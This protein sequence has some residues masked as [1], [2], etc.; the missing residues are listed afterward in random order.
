MITLT[1]Q[2]ATMEVSL[3]G[4]ELRRYT[5]K[6]GRECLWSGDPYAWT[7]VA[8]VLFPTIGALKNQTVLIEN[9]AF[10]IPK[11]GL[12]RHMPFTV[13]EQGPDFITL[14]VTQ[15]EETKACYPFDFAFFVT[16]RFVENGFETILKIENHSDR[17]M[18]F[19]VG[20]HPAFSC[21]MKEGESFEEYVVEFEKPEE[22]R[23]LLMATG[24][25]LSGEEIVPLGENHRTL[26]LDYSAFDK[27]DTYVFSDINSR[28]I[29][30]IHKDTRKG[31]KVSFPTAPVLA[32][33]TMTNKKAPYLC[34]EP[35]EGLPALENETGHFED[36]PYCIKLDM[37]KSY[38]FSYK[39]QEI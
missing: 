11:H 25:I 27:R 26:S 30:L 14:C 28:S 33:W 20:G 4:G 12:V 32:V 37:G 38:S 23:S 9:K 17:T 5:N 35:W 3:K 15:T 18:P 16:H 22:G 13:H 10:S 6:D 21:P 36:K 8:P 1:Y 19:I 34:I 2:G 31:I 7:G 29:S 24:G 39:M